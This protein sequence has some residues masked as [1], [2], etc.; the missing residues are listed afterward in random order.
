MLNK[1]DGC[2][3]FC[4][5]RVVFG[6]CRF[7]LGLKPVR[8]VWLSTFWT[9]DMGSKVFLRIWLSWCSLLDS[10]I[11]SGLVRFAGVD[12]SCPPSLWYRLLVCCSPCDCFPSVARKS[13][14]PAALF[15]GLLEHGFYY[16][17]GG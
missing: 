7:G 9:C 13:V 5:F 11:F 14:I 16:R 6:G 2:V 8:V 4:W 3:L 1:S 15:R 17:A 12:A 10:L